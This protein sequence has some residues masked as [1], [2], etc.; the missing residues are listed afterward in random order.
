MYRVARAPSSTDREFEAA[1]RE[2]LRR[3]PWLALSVGCHAALFFALAQ[4]DFGAE[5]AAEDSAVRIVGTL[6]DDPV[7]IEPPDEVE[8]PRERAIEPVENEAMEEIVESEIGEETV[9]E[10]AAIAEGPL[11]DAP[12]AGPGENGV[13]GV[14]GG[15]GGPGGGDG[16]RRRARGGGHA[17]Q[18]ALRNA[19]D[20]LA[21]HQD[22][23]GHWSCADFME[24][25]DSNR[26]DGGGE[27]M[28][29]VGVSGLALLAFLG[30]GETQNRGRYRDTV[31]RGLRALVRAQDPETGCIGAPNSHTAFLYD[32]ALATLALTEGH[33][34]SGAPLL[35]EPAER[36]VRFV[37]AARN[38]Y[39]GWRY[40]WPPNG[41]NDTSVTAW[42]V[43]CLKSAE[44]FGLPVDAA[45][46]DG[47]RLVLDELT[48][49]ATWRTGYDRIGS[50]SSREQG[51]GERWP[52]ER[53]EA[54]TAAAMLCR[55][56]LGEEPSR[57]PALRGGADL[58]RKS[59]PRF[60]AESGDVDFYYWY[61]G[62]YAMFQ[63]GGAD[64]DAWQRAL[65]GAVVKT[66]RTDGHE[67]GSWDPQFDP[68][69]H[70]GGRV[71]ATALLA[72][73]L[74][75]YYRYDRVVGAR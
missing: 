19:L 51:L 55:V 64:W 38:P 71:Y 46:Y 32:H 62:S 56:F 43:M 4:F 13:L 20:W 7:P 36:A 10:E 5:R 29:D 70:R 3:A 18:A 23:A 35:R 63:L 28:H 14:G 61:Y 26:C 24:R 37:H 17:S 52:A 67:A 34:L 66:Q 59:L 48:D 9:S 22:P 47:A 8:P 75:V 12:F 73:T 16:L 27:A 6:E 31:R 2:N 54:M 42:M 58:L 60:D 68:W 21:R 53:T 50:P 74:E 69:G 44:H 39:R 72:L 15:A 11:R 45:A 25:C 33:G 30:A 40:A 57:S 1:L 65:L 41:E 49:E